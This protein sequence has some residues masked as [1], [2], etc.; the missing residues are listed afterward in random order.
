MSLTPINK[1]MRP[2]ERM[3]SNMW[4]C[5]IFG[6]KHY[7]SKWDVEKFTN[8]C[9]RCHA[10]PRRDAINPEPEKSQSRGDNA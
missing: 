5:W 8:Y 10:Y 2:K 9:T 3:V 1:R 6:H 4:L 7:M